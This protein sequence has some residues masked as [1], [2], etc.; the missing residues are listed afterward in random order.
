MN[1]VNKTLYIP[2]YGKS[3]VS[4]KAIILDDKKA[5]EIWSKVNFP[6]RGKAKSKWLAYYMGMR[7]AVFDQWLKS[8]MQTK[9][10]Y[11]V[12]HLGC[13][14]DSRVERVQTNQMPWYDVDFKEVVEERRKYYQES[15]FYHI[16][17]G[18]LTSEDWLEQIPKTN[19][20]IVVLE[21]VSMYLTNE[22]LTQ[23]F[24][25]LKERFNRVAILLDCYTTFAAK[26]SKFKNPVNTVG[27]T[28]V[29]GIENAKFLEKNTGFSFIQEHE[30]TPQAFINQ[31]QGIEKIIF[32]RLYA[33][34]FSKKLYKLY[35]YHSK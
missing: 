34:N 7:A 9:E 3:L 15:N 21:G 17:E 4:Q 33:G 26:M 1:S 23:L 13:G 2:L 31:L 19:A 10:N 29:Y 32:K 27:V 11:T 24:I 30:I 12:L 18:D 35:E 5:E 6:L 28:N 25:R 14:L 16:L 8:K 22:E 20:A